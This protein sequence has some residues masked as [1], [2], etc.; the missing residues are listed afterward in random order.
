[1]RKDYLKMTNPCLK[2][3]DLEVLADDRVYMGFDIRAKSLKEALDIMSLV[4]DTEISLDSEIIHC[5]EK[6]IH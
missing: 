5:E 3:Y 2:L 6:A 1:M 4:Y